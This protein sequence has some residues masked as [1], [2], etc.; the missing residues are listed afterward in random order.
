MSTTLWIQLGCKKSEVAGV[1]NDDKALIDFGPMV[2]WSTVDSHLFSCRS[3]DDEAGSATLLQTWPVFFRGWVD[4]FMSHHDNMSW[5]ESLSISKTNM[6][7]D[8]DMIPETSNHWIQTRNQFGQTR[9]TCVRPHSTAGDPQNL[10][11][12]SCKWNMTSFTDESYQISTVP[13]THVF[14]LSFNLVWLIFWAFQRSSRSVFW[15]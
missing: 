2:Y 4:G 14:L 9:T 6:I 3:Q 11:F 7:W 12:H 15:C 8:D 13:K 5:T 10:G 1:G